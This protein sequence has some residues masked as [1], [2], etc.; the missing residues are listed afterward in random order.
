MCPATLYCCNGT[1]TQYVE[2]KLWDT[3]DVQLSL[4][5]SKGD[6]YSS[7]VLV[8]LAIPGFPGEDIGAR[9]RSRGCASRSRM[10]WS[11][12]DNPQAVSLNTLMLSRAFYK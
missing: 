2:S 3:Q 7:M 1:G 11:F 10:S 4:S 5:T 9:K 8:L 12:S 6:P